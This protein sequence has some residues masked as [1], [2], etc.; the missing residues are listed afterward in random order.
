M[1]KLIIMNFGNIRSNNSETV[2]K[3]EILPCNRCLNP[4]QLE[5]YHLAP[6]PQVSSALQQ[7]PAQSV[8]LFHFLQYYLSISYHH[9]EQMN[10]KY[11]LQTK[12]GNVFFFCH[13]TTKSYEPCNPN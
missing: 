9:N 10:Y 8:Q 4:P 5:I 12:L 6:K 2:S 7:Q 13:N 3:L 1:R 11:I